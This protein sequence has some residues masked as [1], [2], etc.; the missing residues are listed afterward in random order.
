MSSDKNQPVYS[1]DFLISSV[2]A[3]AALPIRVS[4]S[5]VRVASLV[6]FSPFTGMVS[7]RIRLASVSLYSLVSSA[8]VKIIDYLLAIKIIKG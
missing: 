6:T 5:G 1:P 4:W 2:R 3:F 7:C 8:I